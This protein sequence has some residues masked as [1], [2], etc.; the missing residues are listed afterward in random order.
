MTAC[1]YDECTQPVHGHGYCQRH[2]YWAREHGVLGPLKASYCLVE[3]CEYQ[4]SAY[5]QGLCTKHLVRAKNSNLAEDQLAA[6]VNVLEGQCW[7]CRD[8]EGSMVDSDS[9]CRAHESKKA[10]LRCVRGWVCAACNR[11]LT[12]AGDDPETLTRFR[13]T[14]TR[15]PHV[16]L[17]AIAYLKPAPDSERMS[18][19]VASGFFNDQNHDIHVDGA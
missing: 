3:G 5:G 16:Y 14:G 19:L 9:S 8:A 11:T 4:A 1:I 2:Y 6:L 18:T 15:P 17:R 12:A 10:C 7:I 13:Y